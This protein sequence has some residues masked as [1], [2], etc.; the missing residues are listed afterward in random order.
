MNRPAL[1]HRSPEKASGGSALRW[2]NPMK[3]NLAILTL[4]VAFSGPAAG[5]RSEIEAGRGYYTDGEFK[6]AAAHFQLA[7]K[8]DPNSA[9]AYYWMGMSYQRLADIALPFGGGYNAKARVYLTRAVVLAP[10]RPD[11]RQELFEF[12]LDPAASSRST[13]RQAAG[14]LQTTSESDPD[15]S[16]MRG[17]F[18]SE[19]K[20]NSSAEARLGRLF[21]AVPQAAYRIA[22]LP[23]LCAGAQ[24]GSAPIRTEA[25]S[26]ERGTIAAGSVSC[27]RER[28]R[29]IRKEP[30]E[31]RLQPGLAAPQS[32]FDV[33]EPP[34]G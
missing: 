11:Y 23:A 20:A 27:G 10:S 12:L 34:N 18:E 7:L 2:R 25:R 13:L 4:L 3:V 6:K 15:Y 1:S 30:A 9:E 33:P 19:S 22:E 29:A 17:R 24:R 21:L 16:Y 8:T 14:I 5:Q 26:E 31:S 28:F 32:A